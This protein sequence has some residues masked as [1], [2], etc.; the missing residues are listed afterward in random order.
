[1]SPIYPVP[2]SSPSRTVGAADIMLSRGGR[3]RLVDYD[4]SIR[5]INARRQTSLRRRT[6]V[7]RSATIRHDVQ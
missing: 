6:T 4:W 2:P 3:Q 7:V 1:L 5:R